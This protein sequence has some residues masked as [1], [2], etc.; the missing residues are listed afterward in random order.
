MR[1]LLI[2]IML[3]SFVVEGNDKVAVAVNDLKAISISRSENAII[4]E[5]VRSELINT[6]KYRVMERSQ[7]D[8]ILQEQGFQQS[9]ACSDASCLVEVGQMLAVNQI[10]TGSVGLIGD[11]YTITLKSVD[12]ET[13]EIVST[14][15][16][17]YHGDISGLLSEGVG[18][19]VRKL[20]NGRVSDNVDSASISIFTTPHGANVNLNGTEIGK[21]PITDKL[22]LPGEVSVILSKKHYLPI[23]TTF[24]L[25]SGEKR[26][27]SLVL[28]E[29]NSSPKKN[30][31]FKVLGFSIGGAMVVAGTLVG[32]GFNDEIDN[33]QNEYDNST[34]PKEIDRIKNEMEDNVVYRN[35]S[36][37]GAGV[38]AAL[39]GVS[40]FF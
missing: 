40:F 23:D 30:R 9:G 33:L 16:L 35:I 36:Y 19:V 7:M 32:L 21:T 15:T 34:D 4:S 38:G 37:I 14:A 26:N 28:S 39:V 10:I 1:L 22:L 12:V 25:N 27:I 5:R 2:F 31:V 24:Y 20:S 3:T 8:M 11:M 6:G 18:R 29:S 13:G 17:D